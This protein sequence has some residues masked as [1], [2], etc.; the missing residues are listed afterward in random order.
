VALI[1]RAGFSFSDSDSD[2]ATTTTGFYTSLGLAAHRGL[3]LI[4]KDG[5][6][7]IPTTPTARG[8]QEKALMPMSSVLGAANERP[9]PGG[10]RRG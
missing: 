3:H 7:G 6:E 9:S 5:Q 2:D 8:L 1:A 4:G 10:L